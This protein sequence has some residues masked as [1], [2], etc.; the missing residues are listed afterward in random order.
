MFYPVVCL[1]FSIFQTDMA[2][3]G[4][5]KRLAHQCMFA[6]HL[7]M[8][9]GQRFNVRVKYDVYLVKHGIG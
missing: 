2:S 9:G 7:R 5:N 3:N 6:S 1:F 4:F 8:A